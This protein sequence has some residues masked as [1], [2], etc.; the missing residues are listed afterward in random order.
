MLKI[1]KEVIS[2]TLF[3][4]LRLQDYFVVSDAA[5]ELGLSMAT[6]RFL[7]VSEL[8]KVTDLEAIEE[9]YIPRIDLVHNRSSRCK[10]KEKNHEILAIGRDLVSYCDSLKTDNVFY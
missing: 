4:Y 2:S 10:K 8:A 5:K 9:K 3:P 7:T 6:R 1:P